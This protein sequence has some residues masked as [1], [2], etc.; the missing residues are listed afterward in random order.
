MEVDGDDGNAHNETTTPSISSVGG[1]WLP[2][3]TFEG[4]H[5]G[6]VNAC[7]WVAGDG[8]S[9]AGHRRSL[10]DSVGQPMSRKCAELD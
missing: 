2:G 5:E 1:T 3:V 9:P 4:Q 6:F 7:T 8:E 10:N